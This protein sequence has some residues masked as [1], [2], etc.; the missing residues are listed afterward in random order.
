M[1]IFTRSSLISLLL[2]IFFLTG[3]G[4][5]NPNSVLNPNDSVIT[6]NPNATLGS[7]SNPGIPSNYSQI[8]K[9]IRTVRLSWNTDEWKCYILHTIPFRLHYPKSYNPTANDGKKYPILVFWH[10]DGEAGP[11]TDNECSLANGGPIFQS[12]VDNGQFDGYV[13]VFQSP[14]S[15]SDPF[16][17][18]AVQVINYMVTNNKVDPYR[19]ISNGLSAGGYGTWGMMDEY[20]QYVAAGLPMSGI[21]L[22]D[23]YAANM[24]L[25]KFTPTWD[26]KGGL[27]TGPDP[28]TAGTVIKEL[29][30]VGANITYTLY[31][32]LGHGTWNTAWA[33][34]N[35]FPFCLAAYLSNPWP[36]GGR[37]QFCPGTNINVTIGVPPGLDAYVWRKN[38]VVI[39]G[40]TADTIIATSI[41]TYDC[42]V[43]R[44]GIWSDFSHT[45]VVL[46]I[47]PPTVTPPITISGLMS[48]VIPSPASA[49]VTLKVP[50][51]YATYA[52]ERVGDTTTLSKD[53]TLYVTK[54][55]SY[56]AQV[57]QQF[58][59][60]SNWSPAFVV[61]DSAGP[62]KPDAASQVIATALSETSQELDWS[63]NPTPQF[64]ETHFE[65]YQ[66]TKPSGAY[67]LVAMTGPDVSRDTVKGLIPGTQYYYIIR[68]VDSTSASKLSN[69]AG[70]P[71]IAD[72]SAPTAPGNLTITTTGRNSISLKWTA[73]TDNVGVVA[74]D[75]YVN[76]NKTYTVAPTQ[77][78]FTVDELVNS[79]VYVITVKARD[80]AGNNS[81]ASNQVSGEALIN[82]LP[83]KYYNNLSTAQS[84]VPNYTTLVPAATGVSPTVTL[85]PATA[86]VDF[87]FLWEGY[88]TIP[89]SGNY[90]F[91]ISSDDGSNFYLGAL[92]GV[93]SPYNPT[94]K[95]TINDDGLH[96]TTA[97]N[98]S[99]M[100][101]TAGVYPIALAYFQ[102]GGGD[103]MTLSWKTP[104][105][106]NSFVAVPAS[107]FIQSPVVTGTAPAAPSNLQATA[108]SY[109]SIG[110]KWTD[111]SNNETGFEIYRSTDDSTGYAI[112]QTTG[113]AVTS[114]TD[115]TVS[116]NTRYYYQV[117]SINQYGASIYTS[118]YT[119]AEWK[120]NNNYADSSG[121][122][123]TLTPINSPGFDASNKAEGGYSVRLNGTNQ[124]ITINNASSFLQE[125]YY[126]RTIA[127]WIKSSSTSGA[128]RV[129]W[130]VGGRDNGLALVLN[131]T[132]L[133]AAVASANKRVSINTSYT[134]TG[135][136]HIAVVYYGDSLLLYVNGTLAARNTNLGFHSLSTT[137]NGARIGQTNGTNAY[138]TTGGYFGGWIDDFGVYNQA[139]T[140]DVINN[141]KNLAFVPSNATTAAPPAAPAAPTGLVATATGA[142]SVSV[143][144][145][146]NATNA[147]NYKVYRSNNNNQAYVLIATLPGNSVSYGDLGLF[148]NA[149]YYYKV[150]A[151]NAG[152]AS[153]FSNEGSVQTLDVAPV[154]AAIG[155]RNVRYGTVV[156]VPVSASSSSGSA[157]TLSGT[158]LPSFATLAESG[159]A[160]GVLTLSPVA[161]N[162]GVYNNITITATD[163]YGGT[164]S[165]TFNVT[166]NGNYTPVIASI[167]STSMNEGD[168]L[169]IPVTATDGT[170]TA[171]LSWSVNH[172]PKS[173]SI[174][175][176]GNGT[177]NLVLKPGYSSTGVYTVNV[178]VN[179]GMG[180]STTQTFQLTGVKKDPKAIG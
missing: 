19:V 131:N 29:Q 28:V 135:W 62:N 114:F 178:N 133:I 74:Y 110:L 166:V 97:V 59:C 154:M 3:Y 82:G 139:L 32:T 63:Q 115:N 23:G 109:Q 94:G 36:L 167:S 79:Q 48:R 46:S 38:G 83:W 64:N 138:N 67:S 156:T 165:T 150:D 9:W 52:W 4:Q 69:Q 141:L 168:S 13:L 117:R 134:S 10:G 160:R 70:A 100:N 177:A 124:A 49:G 44:G 78:S 60:S 27:D 176:T 119:E 147:L 125:A 42:Q 14:G 56:I 61:A 102:Q 152:G 129:I 162:Q 142:T 92:N 84:V 111:N 75:I 86:T 2:M 1:T 116:A 58:G 118:S 103:A 171:V 108:L 5:A 158:N 71:T 34:P 101:L 37:T 143:T 15:W 163:S 66:S 35:F 7:L 81:A 128:N 6:Y 72:T 12:A 95:P 18:L 107:A 89:T 76:G 8:Y 112:I 105:S 51:G 126:Q 136:N 155:S 145:T 88:I 43:E 33:E 173:T 137:T 180:D 140:S 41:G 130:E 55:G 113:P 87:G 24:Q 170:T 50:A 17:D 151:V 127:C 54:P 132:T 31:P 157:L 53:S 39:P 68:A 104:S 85:S 21:T 25:T 57:T 90:V 80:Q 169:V 123:R 98:S 153:A 47:M 11:A 175:T 65:V 146:N 161:A 144:W 164:G 174:V 20:P 96:G 148:A 106:P 16:F 22:A 120:F 93:G 77:T 26:F 172:A 30:S 122:N 40:A 179:D 99:T 159:N 45:P 149:L 73:S 121:N 91:Q